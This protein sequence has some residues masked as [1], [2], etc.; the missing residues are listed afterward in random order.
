M[1]DTRW[2]A[3]LRASAVASA[4]AALVAGAV[5]AVGTGGFGAPAAAQDGTH[6]AAVEPLRGERAGAAR[7][8]H[9]A[10]TA[11]TLTA[12]RSV[13]AAEPVFAREILKTGADGRAVIELDDGAVLTL[14][15]DAV[16]AIDRMVWDPSA[17][18][19]LAAL[20]VLHGAFRMVSGELGAK[21][22]VRVETPIATIGVRGTDFW[23]YQEGGSLSV[24]LLDDGRVEIETA[25]GRIVLDEPRDGV[26]ITDPAAPLPATPQRW[27]ERRIA[28]AVETIAFP[29]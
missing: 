10:L 1:R 14:G 11:E 23:G 20:T 24:V 27:G 18:D 8:V 3:R 16:V 29:Q 22:R 9:R 21:G 25:G 17:R 26:T 6:T 7:R 5:G 2:K 12:R 4:L 19:G 15:E 13:S 28:A